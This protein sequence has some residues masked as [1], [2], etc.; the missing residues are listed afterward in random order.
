[1]IKSDV[2]YRAFLFYITHQGSLL[3][4]GDILA[5][6]KKVRE[7]SWCYLGKEHFRQKKQPVQRSCGRNVLRMIQ[8]QQVVIVA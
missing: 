2:S 8:K 7:K 6:L 4:E 1:M 3:G 5:V